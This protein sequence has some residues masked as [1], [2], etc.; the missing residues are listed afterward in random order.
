MWGTFFRTRRPI[1]L[2]ATNAWTALKFFYPFGFDD[3]GLPTE[4]FVEKQR[5][6]SATKVGR[7]EFIKAC[8]EETQVVEK[9]F[10]ELWK[11]IGLSVDWNMCYSTISDEMRKISQASFIDLYKKGFIYRKD[12]PALYCTAFRTSVAQAELEDVEKETNFNDIAFKSEDGD[13]LIIGT[14]RP[15]LLASCVAM[16]YHP[17]DKRYQKYAGKKAIVPIYGHEVSYSC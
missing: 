15:E 10:E 14:T 12:E 6:I 11:R 7:S 16:F 5:G 1:L 2:H 9:Q 8:L 17:D 4:R 13:D 3:N